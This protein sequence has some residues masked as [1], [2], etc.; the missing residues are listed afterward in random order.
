MQSTQDSN[1]LL[2]NAWAELHAQSEF[3]N[4]AGFRAGGLSLRAIER[5]EIGGEVAGKRLLHLMCHFGLDTLSWARLGAQVTGVDLSDRAI[6][7]ARALSQELNLPAEFVQADV[8]SL[9]QALTGQFDIVYTSYGILHWI[10]DLP[11]WAAVVA[12]FVKPGGFFYMVEDHP[13]M[14]V[15]SSTETGDIVADNPYF[16]DPEPYRFE[17]Q[18]SYAAPE[19]DPSLPVQT[20]YMWDHSLSELFN[21]LIG[22]GLRLE[23]FHE[24]RKHV[25]AKFPGMQP[26]ADGWYEFSERY[27]NSVPLLMSLK[28]SQPERGALSAE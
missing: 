3:Y 17:A 8:L 19:V 27:R 28:A 16:F 15:F 22:A 10:S 1:R 5:E 11:R 14:R 20:G 7:I 4:V 13:F 9:P 18:G 21:A 6:A 12:H 26:R 25:R 2:W 23:W 24:H